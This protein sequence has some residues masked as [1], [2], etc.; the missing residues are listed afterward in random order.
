M[1]HGRERRKSCSS[2]WNEQQL[3]KGLAETVWDGRFT[4]VG[5]RPYFIVDGAHNE[6]A[7]KRLAES[8]Q[9]YFTN[10]RIIYIMGVLKDKEHEKI[11]ALTHEYADQIITV[12]TPDN[13]RALPAYALA[14]E[15]AAVHPKVTAADSLEE[16]VEMSRLLAQRDDVIIAFGSLSFL[17]RLMKIVGYR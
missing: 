16:A 17:G 14:Q 2:G 10:K 7:A 11:I 6:D 13:P 4:V 15:V 1:S 9:F 8:I 3:R 5:K 12:A